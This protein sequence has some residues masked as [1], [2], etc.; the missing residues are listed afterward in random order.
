MIRKCVVSAVLFLTAKLLYAQEAGVNC[1]LAAVIV[2][3]GQANEWP[4]E[5]IQDD[6][7]KFSYNFCAD[8]NNLY[9]RMKT[10][11]EYVR[12][13]IA[14]FGLTLWMDPA[15]KKKKKLGLRF[16]SGVEGKERMEAIRATMNREE[17]QKMSSTE[18]AQFQKDMNKSL[19]ADLEVIE[20]EGLADDPI[21]STRSGITTGIKVA[22]AVADDGTY[23]Y[24]AII[25]FKSFRMSRTSL[26]V[27]GVG[28]ETGKFT[29]SSQPTSSKKGAGQG[30]QMGAGGAG[31]ANAM[32]RGQGYRG[33]QANPEMSSASSVWTSLKMK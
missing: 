32:S 27:L 26:D 25:P 2:V 15:G 20:L 16:P 22:I 31:G 30:R 7:K 10:S 8:A 12:R 21:T 14:L 6:D 19:V 24:E 29:S 3:D 1:D 23:V 11:D 4:M 9:A 17:Q 33:V 13:K 18:R 28:F 5:W